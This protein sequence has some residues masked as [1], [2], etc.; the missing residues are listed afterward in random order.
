M[1]MDGSREVLG[2]WFQA[3]EGAKFW[4]HVLSELKQRGVQNIWPP[5]GDSCRR[6]TGGEECET[7][8]RWLMQN[9][10]WLAKLREACGVVPATHAFR[11]D[12]SR[13]TQ[14]MEE[15]YVRLHPGRD[16]RSTSTIEAPTPFEA[17]SFGT[18]ATRA[19]AAV[20]ASAHVS[21]RSRSCSWRECH[22]FA[23]MNSSRSRSGAR[24]RASATRTP[25]A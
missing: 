9:F 19:G 11:T 4:M 8:V 21:A 13:V 5:S 1:G 16:N 14:S 24:P 25:A 15:T 12:P 18:A 22:E 20:F 2:M 10:H 17:K 6:L 3:S 23:S 7:P